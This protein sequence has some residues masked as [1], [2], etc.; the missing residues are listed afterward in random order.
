MKLKRYIIGIVMLLIFAVSL[1][2]YAAN[3]LPDSQWEFQP[4]LRLWGIDVA[5]LYK[6]FT[7][8]DGLDTRLWISLGGGVEGTGFYRNPDGTPYYIPDERNQPGGF[9]KNQLL[10]DAWAG[11]GADLRSGKPQKPNGLDSILSKQLG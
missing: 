1:P 6:G 10:M 3:T 9:Y 7:F 11:S 4:Y 5:C 2:A 8:I